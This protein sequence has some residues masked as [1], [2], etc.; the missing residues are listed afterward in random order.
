MSRTNKQLVFFLL[1]AVALMLSGCAI[2]GNVDVNFYS[3][4]GDANAISKT[5]DADSNVGLK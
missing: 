1:A 4:D 3:P 5:V 2:C